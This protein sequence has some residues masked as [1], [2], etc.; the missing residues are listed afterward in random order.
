MNENISTSI[1]A[2]KGPRRLTLG[3]EQARSTSNANIAFVADLDA[4]PRTRVS[5]AEHISNYGRIPTGMALGMLT[6]TLRVAQLTGRGGAQFPFWKKLEAVAKA[7]SR[8]AP[9]L[10]A[11][12]CES[13]PL[14]KKDV[15]LL[16]NNPHLV[17]DG[18]SILGA[19]L[20]ARSAYVY[21]KD[22]DAH[23]VVSSAIRERR[24]RGLDEVRMI[25]TEAP[26]GYVSGQETA[27]VRKIEKGPALPRFSTERI[28]TN[29]VKGSPT[30]LSNVE[31]F[32]QLAII[33]R[34]GSDWYRNGGNGRDPGTR[35]LTVVGEVERP[36]VYEVTS[37]VGM[38]DILREAGIASV[39]GLLV[40]G[41]FG[42]WINTASVSEL[43]FAIDDSSLRERKLTLGAG[44][45]GVLAKNTCPVVESAGI[46]EYLASQSAGQCGPCVNGLPEI[47]TAFARIALSSNVDRGLSELKAVIPLV[48][49]RGG[50]QH[51]DGVIGLIRSTVLAF[52]D[53][54]KLHKMNKCSV[55]GAEHHSVL[56]PNTN[57][58]KSA[59]GSY[60]R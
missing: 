1:M 10:V 2:P 34:F 5:L 24:E 51:P 17:L 22:R 28:A 16:R 27:V 45:I 15:A 44:I 11:N 60:V 21:I 35:L 31:T 12:G 25:V 3:W 19:V 48:E 43:D 7:G 33:A 41:Y 14:S 9:I 20:G 38:S 8:R 50:C 13:E 30:L 59:V 52:S 18:L 57:L 42:G 49:K 58:I 40:G 53:E 47:S 32:A 56:L 55:I 46:V 37:T 39:R 6:E 36:G 23:S 26:P 29:G 54:I 4:K